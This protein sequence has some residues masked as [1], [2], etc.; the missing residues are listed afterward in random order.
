MRGLFTVVVGA[1]MVVTITGCGSSTNASPAG[2]SSSAA[3]NSST[4]T[5]TLLSFEP[6]KIAVKAGVSVVWRAGDG[7]GH[8]VTTGTFTVGGDGLRSEE[9]PDG[10][11]DMPLHKGHEVS[12]TFTKPG[13]Y[14]YYCSIHKGM[15]GEVDV[16]P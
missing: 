2:G 4:V 8:T 7:I 15:N 16:T 5:T 3:G 13:T 6:A 1:A 14:T 12:F 10:M 11:V 9:H